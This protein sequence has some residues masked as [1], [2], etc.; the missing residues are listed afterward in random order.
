MEKT[1]TTENAKNTEG[2]SD[3]ATSPRPNGFPSPPQV[4][5]PT[6]DERFALRGPPQA[7]ERVIITVDNR[8]VLLRGRRHQAND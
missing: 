8:Q 5:F 4:S 3:C 2:T 6:R 7:A 1:L